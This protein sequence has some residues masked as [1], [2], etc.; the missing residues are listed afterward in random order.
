MVPDSSKFPDGISGTA[1]KIHDL[2]LKI[3]IYSDAGTS[4]CAG[5]PGSLG[6]EG[7]DAQTWAE[8]RIDCKPLN[9]GPCL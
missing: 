1:S 6:N 9:F 5:Y 8:W 4:T 2:G 7:I 3:G